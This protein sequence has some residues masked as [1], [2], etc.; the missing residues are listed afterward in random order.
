MEKNQKN[1][2]KQK[3]KPL[4]PDYPHPITLTDFVLQLALTSISVEN[5]QPSMIF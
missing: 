1:K 4:E 5:Y 3:K 2:N